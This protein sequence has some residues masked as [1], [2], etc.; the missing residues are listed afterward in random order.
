MFPFNP[1]QKPNRSEIIEIVENAD[2]LVTYFRGGRGEKWVGVLGDTFS[3][4]HSNPAH[5]LG[6][7]KYSR[8][9]GIF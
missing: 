6:S 5:F 2:I 1:E 9:L 3:V 8:P 4:G 7:L